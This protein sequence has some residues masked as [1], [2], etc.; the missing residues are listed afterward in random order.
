MQP[1]RL[2]QRIFQQDGDGAAILEELAAH[3]YDQDLFVPGQP[4][5]TN[6]NLGQRSVIQYLMKRAAEGGN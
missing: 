1:D 3:F 6:F 5:M 4:D 2:Y